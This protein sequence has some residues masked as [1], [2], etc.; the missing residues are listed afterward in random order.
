M[1]RDQEDLLHSKPPLISHA[2]RALVLRV[3]CIT[4]GLFDKERYQFATKHFLHDVSILCTAHPY[5]HCSFAAKQAPPAKG[6]HLMSGSFTKRV[7]ISYRRAAPLNDAAKPARLTRAE[8]RVVLSLLQHVRREHEI[9]WADLAAELNHRTE[10]GKYQSRP[11]TL[12]S[13]YS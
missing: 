10:A 4:D 9:R 13:R 3:K 6:F 12:P 5:K 11:N 7:H 8:V 2:D 1:P